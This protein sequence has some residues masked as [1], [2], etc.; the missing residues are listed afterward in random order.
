MFKTDQ[1]SE[2]ER[3][4]SSQIISYIRVVCLVKGAGD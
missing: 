2:G 1:R 3:E 4:L